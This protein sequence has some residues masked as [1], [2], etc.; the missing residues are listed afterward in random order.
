MAPP[1]KSEDTEASPSAFSRFSPGRAERIRS[2]R[3]AFSSTAGQLA[4]AVRKF[5]TTDIQRWKTCSP[6]GR[7]RLQFTFGQPPSQ[8]KWWEIGGF[9]QDDIRLTPNLTVNVGLRYDYWAV[10]DACAHITHGPD[11]QVLYGT[12]DDPCESGKLFNRDGPFGPL[13]PFDS[14]YR[15]DYNNFSPRVGFAWKLDQEGKTVLRSG[16]GM[17]HTPKRHRGGPAELIRAD[18]ATP[19]RVVLSRIELETRGI[20]YPDFNEDVIDQFRDPTGVFSFSAVNP[21]FPHAYA[22]Q[23]TFGIQRQLTQS[24]VGEI[25][26]TGNHGVKLI[27]TTNINRVDRL[28][29]QRPR[30]ETTEIRYHDTSESSTYNSLQM[31]LKKRFARDFSFDFFY[32][33]SRNLSF[34]IGDVTLG[35]NTQQE[36]NNLAL[37]HGPTPH[38]TSHRFVADWLYEFPFERLVASSSTASRLL[39]GGWRTGGI[40]IAETGLPINLSQGSSVPTRPDILSSSHEAAVLS[41]FQQTLQYLD[42]NAFRT[43]PIVAISGAG[44]RAGTLGRNALSVAGCLEL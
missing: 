28:T 42:R 25:S 8:F 37:E 43:V 2:R 30:P 31:A 11:G 24:L 14:P 32:T 3:V 41:N 10:P 27:H 36:E 19:N 33:W 38:D 22:F 40:F 4:P 1:E 44:Q 7:A 18:L 20:R 29:G 12:G 15:A 5:L 9:I 39:L 6:T 34:N 26:Y 13:R 17:F 23:W 35:N 16:F 21:D